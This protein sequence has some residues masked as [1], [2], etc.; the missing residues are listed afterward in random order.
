MFVRSLAAHLSTYLAV[1]V[2][3]SVCQNDTALT[4]FKF[5]GMRIST[6]GLLILSRSQLCVQK[7]ASAVPAGALQIGGQIILS[8][9]AHIPNPCW[10]ILGRS[11]TIGDSPS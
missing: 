1:F 7:D 2:D 11:V 9:I 5:S 10:V 8:T 6:A 3:A 4:L